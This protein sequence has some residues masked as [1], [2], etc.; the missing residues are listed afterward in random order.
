MA[1]PEITVDEL[2]TALHSGSWLIDVREPDEYLSGHV[3]GALLVP[4]ADVPE[5]LDRFTGVAPNYLICRS[6]GRS[7]RACE[8]LAGH[9]LE[10]INV[11]GGTMAWIASGRDVVAGDAPT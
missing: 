2:E 6:G 7:L 9:G 4:L 8:F 5:A 11:I 3:P 10:V 1:I